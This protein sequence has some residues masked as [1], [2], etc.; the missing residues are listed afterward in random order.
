MKEAAT[1]TNS[2]EYQ[3]TDVWSFLQLGCIVRTGASTAGGQWS[4]TNP[5]QWSQKR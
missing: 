4:F 3:L 1:N 2:M 5:W